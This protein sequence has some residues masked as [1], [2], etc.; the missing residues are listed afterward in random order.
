[1]QVLFESRDPEAA[2]FRELAERRLKFVMRRLSWVA[3]RVRVQLSDVN[4]PRGGVDKRCLL[5][6]ST[7]GSGRVVIVALARDWR[8]ALEAA[9]ARAGRVLVRLWRR[10]REQQRSGK[11][12]LA[13][14]LA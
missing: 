9:F 12:A 3:P 4:G 14:E 6:L 10:N 5:E 7:A 1:M 2:Q 11:R 13:L 8:G